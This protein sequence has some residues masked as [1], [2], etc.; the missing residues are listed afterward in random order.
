[1]RGHATR[2]LACVLGDM[3]LVRPLGL[4]GIRCAVAVPDGAPPRYSRFVAAR[5]DWFDTWE[6]PKKLV[7]SLI[8]FASI[9]RERPVLFYESD[10]DLLLISRHR[11]RLREVFR[12]VI[13]DPPLVEALVDKEKF[14]R[15]A[16]KLSLPVPRARG[17]RPAE[18]PDEPSDLRFPVI[19]K[20]LTRLP[21]RWEPVAGECKATEVNSAAELRRIW[22]RLAAAGM[23][24]LIQEL[25][26]GTEAAIESYHVYVDDGDQIR[27]EF[28]GRKVRTYPYRY[29]DSTALMITNEPDVAETGR[30][31]VRRLGLRGVAKLDFKRA[32][33]GT[34]Y[35]LEINPRF[36]LWH[37]PGAL[38]GVN[39]PA[40]VYGDLTGSTAT[41]VTRTRAGVTWCRVWRDVKAAGEL[42]IPWFEW[43]RWTLACEAKSN[44]AWDDP[45]PLVL[46]TMW[47]L[48]AALRLV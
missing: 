10:G 27:A 14:Q 48:R 22:Q 41:A 8:H 36:T 11:E 18:S 44:I 26:P 9:Q 12:F 46:A 24:V 42:N 2:P 29:G 16:E 35:L 34:L 31:I 43:I 28:T 6:Q 21:S 3:D 4:A 13:A 47:R 17:F 30:E 40:L 20:P 23:A 39:I 38:A 19:V 5:L 33:D 1:M 15:L 45:L 32:P 37:H 7:E 25:I